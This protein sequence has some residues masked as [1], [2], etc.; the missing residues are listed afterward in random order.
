MKRTL[1]C[2]FLPLI[3]AIV[4]GC[5]SDVGQQYDLIQIDPGQ[6]YQR[7]D[8]FGTCIVNYKEFPPE[9]FDKDFIDKVVY[10]LGLSILRIPINE[11]LE[12][13]NDDNDPDHFNWDGFY[14]S[15]NNR[16]RG[17]AETMNFVQEFKNRGV[18]LFMASPWSPPQFMKTNRAPIQGG[19]LRADMYD[20]FAEFLAAYIILAKKNWDI[21]IRW[22]SLQNESI[23]VEFYR[24]C[25]YH[26]YG[27]KEALRAVMEK[28]DKENINTRILINEDVLYPDRVS[29]FL[30]PVFTDPVTSKYNGDIA[31]HRNAQDEELIRWVELTKDFNR[32]YLMTETSGH[33][34]TWIGAMN[35]AKDIHEYLVLG[36]FSAWIY[37]QISGN[38]GGSNPGLYT[39]MLEGK[40]TKKYYTS[41]HYY[42]FIRPGAI[43]ISALASN[44]SLLVSAYKHPEEGT[45]TV[46]MINPSSTDITLR[47]DPNHSL[48]LKFDVN[49]S[50]ETNLFSVERKYRA[51]DLLVIPANSIVSLCGQKRSLKELE[52][53][54]SFQETLIRND[55]NDVMLGNFSPFPI[56]SEWQ[57]ASDAHVGRI[58]QAETAIN[59]GEINKQRYDGWSL[60]HESILNGDGDAVKYLIVNGADINIPAKDGWTPLHAAASCFVGNHDIQIKNKEYNQ[61]EIFRM[62]LDAGAD[63][64]ATT[65]DGWTPLHCA[66]INANTGWMQSESISVNRIRDLLKAGADLE[67]R[68]M[69]GRTPL[70]WAAIQ[71]Y[72]HFIDEK[73]IVESDI[74]ELLINKGANV[75][76]VDSFGRSPLHYAVQMGYESISYELVKSHADVFLADSQNKTPVDLAKENNS[77]SILY[78][79]ENKKLPDI[80][81]AKTTNLDMEL[82]SAATSGDIDMV[83]YL[84]REGASVFYKD[85]D[86]FRAIDRARDNGYNAIVEFL[87][88]T[89][90]L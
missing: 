43:R 22:I 59:S 49:Q 29:A 1:K 18:N 61:Y 71:G 40:P 87:A 82:I 76:S 89:E 85:S 90:K 2:F 80:K 6:E 63:V 58:M 30:Q 11:H 41:K 70:H 16:I 79:L 24:S 67:A 46:V 4:T 20:E 3:I 38:T 9:Y 25:L 48:P 17:M 21:D 54:T 77:E 33:D 84:I 45:L 12:F 72:S 35:L 31:V 73:T 15:N 47:L 66:V 78:I 7:I 27:M 64:N 14:M 5:R 86:G 55:S 34:T 51:G 50:T 10:D 83:T 42:R 75:N 39:L 26:G 36:N 37:W 13:C 53:A 60:L 57:G 44:D 88:N 81:I 52:K 69:N 56:K 8:G 74:V 65:K 68:D 23:F 28:F 62:V 19:F 32:N